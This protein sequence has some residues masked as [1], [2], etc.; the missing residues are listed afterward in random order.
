[1]AFW[2][3]EMVLYLTWRQRI[4]RVKEVFE[5]S[6]SMMSITYLATCDLQM[7]EMVLTVLYLTRQRKAD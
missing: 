4:G 6:N 2:T 1:M 7:Y 5:I 3:H